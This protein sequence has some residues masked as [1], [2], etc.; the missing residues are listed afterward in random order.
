MSTP[1][2]THNDPSATD[3]TLGRDQHDPA[4]QPSLQGQRTP[5]VLCGWCGSFMR[6][7]DLTLPTS[8]GICLPCR[9]RVWA[10]WIA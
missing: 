3:P 9:A 7:G 1:K 5:M 6:G 8:H 2:I 4:A 10:E